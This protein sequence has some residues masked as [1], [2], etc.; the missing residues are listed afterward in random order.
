MSRTVNVNEEFV[1]VSEGKKDIGKFAV[2]GNDGKF[3]LSVIPGIEEL[4]K[5][6]DNLKNA[7]KGYDVLWSGK[8]GTTSSNVVINSITLSKSLAD[9]NKIGIV[10]YASDGS[11][12][13]PQYREFF[14]DQFTTM[15]NDSSIT[16]YKLTCVWG[17]S[18]NSDYSEIMKT[19]T[20][21][22]LVINSVT[23]FITEIRGIY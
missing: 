12:V 11:Y 20:Y 10:F 13:R 3:D 23:S 18:N 2:L 5:Q 9:Y 19:S 21:T 6:I 14:V 7:N 16:N 8:V 1:V 17:Y 22:S 15:I 4:Q